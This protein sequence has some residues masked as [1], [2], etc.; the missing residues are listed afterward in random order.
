MTCRQMGGMCDHSMTANTPEEMIKLGMAHLEDAHL[1]MANTIKSLGE[2]SPEL[3]SWNK[4][5]MTDWS[6]LPNNE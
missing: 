4:K 6:E 5:F 1:D 3:I 2:D